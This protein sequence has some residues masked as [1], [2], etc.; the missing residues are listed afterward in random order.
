MVKPD[1]LDIVSTGC[2][3]LH[4]TGKWGPR[5]VTYV[6]LLHKASGRKFWHFNTHWCVHDCDWHKRCRGAR[7]MLQIINQKAGQ[8]PKIITGDFN[9]FSGGLRECGV[10]VFTDGGFSNAQ[11]KYVDGVFYSTR[12]WRKIK[13]G[14]GSQSK[15]D[16]WPVF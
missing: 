2:D 7:R 10:K 16:H 5:Y 15:S 13:G 8:S 3:D 4:A 12:D 6:E 1:I 9:A 11:W 14:H